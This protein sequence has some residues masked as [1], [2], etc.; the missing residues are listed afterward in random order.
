MSGTKRLCRTT[1]YRAYCEH[2]DW[3]HCGAKGFDW[4]HVLPQGKFPELRNEVYN[5]I[6][7]CRDCHER[8]HNASKR[9]P[10]SVCAPV[11]ALELSGA[12]LSYIERTY[13][14][15]WPPVLVQQTED[16]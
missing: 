1:A 11:E 16:G 3:C 8:H 10:R 15:D 12:Q 5:I 2:G 13:R 7:I 6:P 9:L 14:H 4:H